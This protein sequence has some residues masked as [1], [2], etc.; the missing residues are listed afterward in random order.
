MD[1]GR[2]ERSWWPRGRAADAVLT[3]LVAA[4]VFGWSIAVAVGGD[5]DSLSP[6]GILILIVGVGAVYFRRS[7]PVLVAAVTLAAS[8]T[9][10]IALDPDGPIIASFA[11]ALY[12]AMAQG[13]FAP[14]MIL[15]AVAVI[16]S[17]YG[18]YSTD[19]E[20]LGDLGVLFFA[21]WLIAIMAVG[22]AVYNRRSYLRE[23][24]RRLRDV[25][26]GREEEVR[27][28]TTEE[29]LR[30]AREL[31]DVL[32]HHLSLINV[33]AGAA[34]HRIDHDQEQASAALRTIKE[35]SR[36]ALREMR[37]TLG[38]LRQ[39]DDEAP[40]GPPPSLAHVDELIAGC[41]A[42]GVTVYSEI[43]DYPENPLPPA[44]DLAGYRIVQEALTN[45]TRHSGHSRATS[46]TVRIRYED[47][48][49]LEIVNDDPG[50]EPIDGPP[51]PAGD[52]GGHGSG[53]FGM[54]ERART[55]G[56]ELVAGP[57]PDGGFRVSARLPLRRDETGRGSVERE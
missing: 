45:V 6:V 33:Q 11:I 8:I 41:E 39:V 48:V 21:G 30:I 29:R 9:Y 12:T 36:Q 52:A 40:T 34:V 56:G 15:G 20:H 19:A 42:A 49:R 2:S 53:V 26:R 14:A 25:E 55:L 10:L 50:T 3:G 47:E 51:D 17:F 46:A 28:R 13:F 16:G 7:Y 5:A 57:R 27:R 32:G 1:D 35:N 44:V 4:L 23:A 37:A 18:E 43:D 38:V 54:R 24:A 22:G 31:H